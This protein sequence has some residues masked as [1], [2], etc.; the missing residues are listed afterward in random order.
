MEP[1]EFGICRTDGPEA[2]MKPSGVGEEQTNFVL[3]KYLLN[4]NNVVLLS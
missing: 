4:R 1:G 3:V 2:T